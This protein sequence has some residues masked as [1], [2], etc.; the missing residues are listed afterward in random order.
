MKKEEKT[1]KESKES[2]E[3][4]LEKFKAEYEKVQKKYNL[5]SF[6]DM[7][8]A[9]D[10]EEVS[11]KNTER[12]LRLIRRRITEKTSSYLRFMEVF[13]NP[14]QAPLFYMMLAKNMPEEGR[15]A[16]NEVYFELGKIELD[17][18]KLEL[19]DYSEGIESKAIKSFYEV[20]NKA[21]EQLGILVE[22]F[23]KQWKKTTQTKD[24]TYLG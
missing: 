22:I 8:N 19:I 14:S 16:V 2:K 15:T 3:N 7:N 9:F 12:I 17:H 10:I 13:L 18:L 4:K 5:P 21:K 11:S 1:T 23:E 20:W 6:E 24:K